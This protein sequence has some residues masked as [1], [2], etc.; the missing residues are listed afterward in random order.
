MTPR[1]LLISE[2]AHRIVERYGA[3]AQGAQVWSIIEETAREYP[4]CWR[5][6]QK[7]DL[8]GKAAPRL[9]LAVVRAARQRYRLAVAKRG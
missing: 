9:L 7:V 8:M 4:S 1:Q 2:S 5:Y 3:A 6:Y